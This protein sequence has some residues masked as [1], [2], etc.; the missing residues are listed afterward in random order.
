MADRQPAGFPQPQADPLRA[1]LP[2]QQPF[3]ELPILPASTR[4]GLAYSVR[5]GLLA[6]PGWTV[7]ARPGG[8]PPRT[9]SARV[10]STDAALSVKLGLRRRMA[11]MAA[12]PAQGRRWRSASTKRR[13]VRS[14]AGLW[15]P[16]AYGSFHPPP[17]TRL[18]PACQC[19]E[20]RRRRHSGMCL[21]P[22]SAR[23]PKLPLVG[24][25]RANLGRNSRLWC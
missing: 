9:P 6:R 8:A 23:F 2:M 14:A 13:G 4:P 21:S 1:P 22:Y 20:N 12:R 24:D 10:R 19:A 25:G 11:W 5:H 18:E 7:S 3:D 16:V 17:V 15:T